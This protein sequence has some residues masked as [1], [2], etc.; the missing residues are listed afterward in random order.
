L[1]DGALLISPP[2]PFY[3]SGKNEREREKRQGNLGRGMG[4]G[5]RR[6]E[7]GREVKWKEGEGE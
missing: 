3:L 7:M 2:H 5:R 6:E 1:A 4:E